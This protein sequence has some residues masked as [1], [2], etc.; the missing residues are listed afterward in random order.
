MG[1]LNDEYNE[2]D[3]IDQRSVLS[4]NLENLSK[5]KNKFIN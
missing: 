2:E 4:L 3:S 1:K 5:N